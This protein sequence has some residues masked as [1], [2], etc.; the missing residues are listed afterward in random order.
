MML[1]LGELICD[2]VHKIH[3]PM[4]PQR[5]PRPLPLLCFKFWKGRRIVEGKIQMNE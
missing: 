1:I 5:Q 3:I 2:T 4:A